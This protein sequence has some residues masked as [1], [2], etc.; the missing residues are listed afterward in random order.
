MGFTFASLLLCVL[1]LH[2]IGKESGWA[3]FLTISDASALVLFAEREESL[4]F[5]VKHLCVSFEE[6]LH[7]SAL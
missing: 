2:S 5:A 1:A 7:G 6:Q 3:L 4:D